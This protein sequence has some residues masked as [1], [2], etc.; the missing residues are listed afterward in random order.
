MEDTH[1]PHCGNTNTNS[2]S[3]QATSE[4][5]PRNTKTDQELDAAA[6]ALGFD[7]RENLWTATARFLR[8]LSV[9]QKALW[10]WLNHP[11]VSFLFGI[12]VNVTLFCTIFR[13]GWKW[14]S[15]VIVV[16]Y[17]ARLS[18]RNYTTDVG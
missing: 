17:Q 2:E 16:S 14:N 11:V 15:L 3:P 6:L 1:Q 18:L 7:N 9:F 13:P 8:A 5:T 4:E 12:L 10:S